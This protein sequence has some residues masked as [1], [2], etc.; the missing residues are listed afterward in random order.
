MR[1][2]CSAEQAIAPAVASLDSGV[3]FLRRQRKRV[4]QC[5]DEYWTLCE[6]VRTD[7]G[8]RQRVVASLG[9]LT[10]TEAG[11]EAGWE[12]LNCGVSWS[13][14]CRAKGWAAA[15]AN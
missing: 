7:Q 8:P 14:G 1:K 15:R 9:K 11:R 6:S 3:M 5:A 13:S 12:D 10:E 2:G 4:G